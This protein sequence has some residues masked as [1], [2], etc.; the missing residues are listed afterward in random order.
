MILS[1]E[2]K[3]FNFHLFFIRIYLLLF[4]GPL[5]VNMSF[6]Q[7]NLQPVMILTVTN[8]TLH[9]FIDYRNWE[10]NPVKIDFYRTQK[11]MATSYS[12]V[13]IQSFMVSGETYKSAIVTLDE[14]P[15]RTENLKEEVKFNYVTDTVFLLNLINGEKKL[16]SFMDIN[17]KA[18]F[19]ITNNSA[20]ELLFSKRYLKK[21]DEGHLTVAQNK[22]YV[23]Q[24]NIY[25]Q[26]CS[27]IQGQ[28]KELKYERNDLVKLFQYYYECTNTKMVSENKATSKNEYGVLAGVS[29]TRLKY[30][31]GKEEYF[32]QADY[33][34]STNFSGGVFYNIVFPRN[35]GR[36][37]VCNQLLYYSYKTESIY[38]DAVTTRIGLN[39][40][41]MNNLVRYKFPIKKVD[42]FLETG[43]TV[44]F[45]FNET[46]YQK[47]AET[48]EYRVSEGKAFRELS[49]LYLGVN[50]GLGF[51]FKK[52]TI[53]SRFMPGFK[54]TDFV[55]GGG[56]V[57]SNTNSVFIM[58]G[59]QF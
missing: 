21:D 5:A 52:Y 45:G 27:T 9:G 17:G 33:P 46:N 39:Y 47:F 35:F 10:K 23:G 31:N 38:D 15:Y 26:K 22:K 30:F 1:N 43:T 29:F 59:Y 37:S 14:S 8:D 24:L 13:E 36:L 40:I 51:Q 41:M 16:Y 4:L 49:K 58:M 56:S 6:A 55:E 57:G 34:V 7:K 48:F 54:K 28:L 19:F 18:H 20:L 3:N 12:P 25:L 44:G 11:D 50:L 42:F 2:M 32:S 53:E